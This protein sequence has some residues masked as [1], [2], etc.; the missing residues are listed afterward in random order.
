MNTTF[1]CLFLF[2][3][4]SSSWGGSEADAEV[5]CSVTEIKQDYAFMR[6]KILQMS[7]KRKRQS[8]CYV[9][10]KQRVLDN[11]PSTAACVSECTFASSSMWDSVCDSSLKSAHAKCKV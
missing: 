6:M 11:R 2:F 8:K 3:S 7:K 4:L 9:K 1:K 10:H 5:E